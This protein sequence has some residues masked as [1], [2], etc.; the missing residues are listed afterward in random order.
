MK[1]NSPVSLSPCLPVSR[2]IAACSTALLHHVVRHTTLRLSLV[3]TIALLLVSMMSAPRAEAGDPVIWDAHRIGGP[4]SV[5]SC[6]ETGNDI[7]E[8]RAR[9]RGYGWAECSILDP[10]NSM[11]I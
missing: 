1:S 7:S 9:T 4:S 5:D 10:Q 3:C 8:Q 11:N 2:T 6:I